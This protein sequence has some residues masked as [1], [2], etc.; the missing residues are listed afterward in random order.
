MVKIFS[1]E[2]LPIVSQLDKCVKF[3]SIQGDKNDCILHKIIPRNFMNFRHLFSC[4]TLILCSKKQEGD[5]IFHTK[6]Q[7]LKKD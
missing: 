7:L 6:L 3:K 1:L 5:C 4:D 2:I